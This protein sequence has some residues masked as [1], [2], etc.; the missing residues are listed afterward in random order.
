MTSKLTSE[1]STIEDDE[2]MDFLAEIKAVCVKHG[3]SIAHED[4]QG[5]FLIEKYNE[6]NIKWMYSATD[7]RHL[8]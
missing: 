8:T 3:L 6:N 5:A 2:L 7:E 1:I 4:N